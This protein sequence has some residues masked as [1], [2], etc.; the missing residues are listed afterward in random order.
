MSDTEADQRP[1]EG[2]GEVSTLPEATAAADVAPAVEVQSSTLAEI[3]PPASGM[4]TIET[5]TVACNLPHGLLVNLGDN[6]LKLNGINAG[7][8]T[9]AVP[10]VA[11]RAWL[12]AHADEDAVRKG[13]IG[14]VG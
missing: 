3:P 4:D 12:A 5:V 11:F 7:S 1:D 13:F 10:A 8:I 14:I 6:Q 2:A 9:Q